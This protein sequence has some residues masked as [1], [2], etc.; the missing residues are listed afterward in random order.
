MS[1]KEAALVGKP[2][3]HLAFF[4]QS[5]GESIYI[6]ILFIIRNFFQIILKG[7]KFLWGK[8]HSLR[9]SVLNVLKYI[10]IFFASP[11]LKFMTAFE[12]M[13]TD[14]GR[15]RAEKGVSAA[16]RAFF[17]HFWL[18]LFGKNGFAV[19]L[20][21]Y[22]A[23]IIS[24]FFLVN[25]ISYSTSINYAVRLEVNGQFLGYIENE[26]AFA[27]AEM[28]VEKR[29]NSLGSFKQIDVS[30]MFAIEKIGYS[31]ILSSNQVAD[32]ILKNSGISVAN[33]FGIMVNGELI[34]AVV[35]N[36]RIK[37]TLESLLDV[38]RSDDSE[39]EVQ[40]EVSIDCEQTGQYITDSIIN[41]QI[42]IDSF[43]RMKEEAKYYTVEYGDSH[44][45]IADILDVSQSELNKLNPG[46]LDNDLYVGQQIK[47]STE[48][49][50][51]SVSVTR[52]E[53]YEIEEPY[54]T[55]YR[56]DPD[57][58]AG[59]TS[60]SRLGLNGLKTVTA[61]VTRVNGIQT[62]S[63]EIKTVYNSKP[64][65]QIVMKGT[66]PPKG[67]FSTDTAGYGKFIWPVSRSVGYIS[68]LTHW[69]GGYYGHLGLDF[70]AP[71]GSDVYAGASGVV[72]LA[73]T[74]Y[75]Y[76][77]CIIIKHANGLSTLYAHCSAI[78]VSVGE[79]V[80]Q[81]QCIGLV[82][83]TGDADGNHVHLEVRDGNIKYNPINYIDR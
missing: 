82:G 52:T 36:S 49:P 30:P 10:G 57:M 79:S 73:Q 48:V 78:L 54:E 8:T 7:V 4:L 44:S 65:T 71:Y 34:G 66:K 14:V 42:I 3:L 25:L 76:G 20:F 83:Q 46:F 19:T 64:V 33:A 40:F 2:A 39:E 55:E 50:Y 21:N 63:S 69:D 27:D 67:T 74:Y 41:D 18:F 32:L 5:L 72:Q 13:V 45:L 29:L 68:Q 81:G 59:L 38:Y 51:L 12:K 35:D 28:I 31:D 17:S 58:Y 37:A 53:V 80:S 24:I 56:D 70:A 22:A 60:I 9:R 47:Y 11:F 77:K 75:N 23:P 26:Q 62:K 43:T 1:Y 61:R 6:I 15:A 16:I